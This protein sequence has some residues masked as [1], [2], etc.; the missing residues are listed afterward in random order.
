MKERLGGREAA[1]QLGLDKTLGW[2]V[3]QLAFSVD[4]E[5][6]V[7]HIPGP[8]AW[9]KIIAALEQNGTSASTMVDLRTAIDALEAILLSSKL[10]RGA[11]ADIFLNGTVSSASARRLLRIRKEASQTAS[12]ILGVRIAARVGCFLVA[13]SQ[14][15]HK[16]DVAVM[17]LI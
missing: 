4:D 3:F 14:A 10:K 1:R 17:A 16:V 12:S 11:I 15:A 8:R 13:P 6:A 2:K 7:K 5:D 9:G